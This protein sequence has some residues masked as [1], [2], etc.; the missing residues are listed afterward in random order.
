MLTFNG[1]HLSPFGTVIQ[2]AGS[3]IPQSWFEQTFPA[4]LSCENPPEFWGFPA[5]AAMSPWH[6]ICFR[7]RSKGQAWTKNMRVG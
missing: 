7:V 3:V 5:L 2:L 6:V 4:K 1:P